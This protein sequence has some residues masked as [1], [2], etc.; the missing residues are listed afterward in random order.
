MPKALIT[1]VTGQD[2][3]Y[4]TEFLL[5][6][7]YEVHGLVR[8]LDSIERSWLSKL[9]RDPGIHNK[10]LFFHP[11]DLTDFNSVRGVVEKTAPDEVYHLAAQSHVNRSFDD[12]HST[13]DVTAMGTLRLLEAVRKMPIPA[14]FFQASSSEIFGR[15]QNSPQTLETAIAPVNPYG[16]AKAFATQ[17]VQVYRSSFG[18]FASNGIL[19]N[20]ESPRRGENFVTKKVCHA[21]AA[22]K[23]GKQN[24][25]LL[26]D[27]TAQRDWGHAL[28][29]V[30]G[31]WM[32]LQNSSAEDFIFA[33]GELHSV[34]EVVEI[35][36]A[37]LELDWRTHVKWD[38]SLLRPV[39][40]RSLVGNP[41][42]AEAVLGWKREFNF[43]GLIREMT[44]AEL[45]L[46]SA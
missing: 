13:C 20:H 28:D 35:A 44:L 25:L 38:P 9:S 26:G 11:G 32:T 40:P 23:L 7:G 22:I 17:M 30:R 36:F 37:T 14:R 2:G 15:P 4:L 31:M 3:S 24:E 6:K 10:R 5:G 1:G 45:E 34:Q 21:A 18:L 46:L 27:T 8:R 43:P 29:Y 16:V 41:E 39:E 19:Y 12:P 33:T 42:K